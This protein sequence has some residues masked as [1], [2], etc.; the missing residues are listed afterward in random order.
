MTEQET[1]KDW[2]EKNWFMAG[3]LQRECLNYK[4]YCDE[5]MACIEEEREEGEK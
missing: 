4:H 5:V 2:E 1:I 3:V